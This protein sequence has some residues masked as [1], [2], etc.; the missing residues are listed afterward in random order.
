MGLV[1]PLL[2]PTQP[3]PE[4]TGPSLPCSLPSHFLQLPR[5]CFNLTHLDCHVLQVLLVEVLLPLHPAPELR[6]QVGALAQLNHH[7]GHA[8]GLHPRL[9]VP[10]E[11]AREEVEPEMC[12]WCVCVRERVCVEGVREGGWDSLYDVPVLDAAEDEKLAQRGLPLLIALP[13][14]ADLFQH[15]PC[16]SV[17]HSAWSS[18]WE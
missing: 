9:Y 11:K 5:E 10:A 1:S 15:V 3:S 16:P 13:G 4:F 17:L 18:S 6:V 8:A 2:S 14:Q 7:A 12:V